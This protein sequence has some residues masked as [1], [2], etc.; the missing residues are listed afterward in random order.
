MR[1]GV[2]SVY[3]SIVFLLI[4]S[5]LMVLLE[6]ARV[7]VIGT[8]AERYADMAAEMVFASYVQPL[9]ERYDLLAVD[10]GAN[11]ES[12]GLFK[13]YLDMNL[14]NG[15]KEGRVFDMYARTQSFGVE[16][17]VSVK[18]DDWK[19]LKEQIERY[20]KYALGTEGIGN[21]K[22]LL[23]QLQ[24]TGV[25]NKVEDYSG[26]LRSEGQAMDEAMTE[27]EEQE[28]VEA[29]SGT[30]GQISD[31]RTGIS[32]W[33]KSGIL[34]LVMGEQSV[35]SRVIDTSKCS[36]HTEETPKQAQIDSF[37]GYKEV[38]NMLEGQSVTE[39]IRCGLQ[40][41]GTQLMV[42][43]YILDKF[44]TL[45]DNKTALSKNENSEL[46]YETEYILFG[47]ETDREN[48]ESTITGICVLRTLL[49]LIYLYTSPEKGSALQNIVQ[50]MSVLSSVP[51]AGTVLQLLL[52]VCW[53]AAEAVVDCAA[54]VRGRKVPLMKDESSWN[55]TLEQ[56]IRI[57]EK[58]GSAAAYIRDGSEGLDYEQYLLI[59]L[60]LTPTEK[61][62][63]RMTQVME[64]NI[65]LINGY[66]QFSFSQCT[67]AAEFSGVVQISE[68]F[69]H[70]PERLQHSFS[71]T[72]SY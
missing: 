41:Q 1:R 20:E 37:E 54:L 47:H 23:I 46:K 64:C 27:M 59:L 9:A 4:L 24:G 36:W 38:I 71:V 26:E 68:M 14:E 53:A 32:R 51:V 66:E 55:L 70:H 72:Y 13:T 12:L 10:T 45:C 48:L 39:I 2:I 17:T 56:L 29:E 35:S 69:W 43:L 30:E 15:G 8:M 25:S 18:D 3:L 31:P 40:E 50:G 65:R 58:G 63:I 21:L 67:V 61:K 34:N 19:C 5:L 7:Y 16:K 57:A 49:N 52:M 44:D 6:S 11:G 62:M 28:S 22:D 60:L 42:N 33:I